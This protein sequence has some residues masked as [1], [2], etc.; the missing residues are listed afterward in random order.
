MKIITWLAVFLCLA[1]C[2]P[3]QPEVDPGTNPVITILPQPGENPSPADYCKRDG[4]K[5]NVEFKNIGGLASDGYM[6]VTVEFATSSGQQPVTR[7]LRPLSPD[8]TATLSYPIPS[9]CFSPD[10]SFGIKWSDQ[11]AIEGVCPG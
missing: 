3:E 1:G 6:D 5:L 9:D 11:P 10:C 4:S 7:T 8:Q 2:S